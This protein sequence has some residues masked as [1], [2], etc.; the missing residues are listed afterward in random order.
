VFKLVASNETSYTYLVMI[1]RKRYS[2]KVSISG[3][4]I[5]IN[6]YN[7]DSTEK[8]SVNRVKNYEFG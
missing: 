4:L 1:D 3:K 6:P 2:V 8:A 7:E 5:N